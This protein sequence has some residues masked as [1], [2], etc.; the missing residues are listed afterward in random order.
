MARVPLSCRPRVSNQLVRQVVVHKLAGPEHFFRPKGG[1]D[2]RR[3]RGVRRPPARSADDR[4]Q[5]PALQPRNS[6]FGSLKIEGLDRVDIS[7]LKALSMKGAVM[8]I[9]GGWSM[10]KWSEEGCSGWCFE[11]SSDDG[12]VEGEFQDFGVVVGVAVQLQGVVAVHVG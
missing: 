5:A 8:E 2:R 1:I 11:E 12:C 3:Q 6:L 4:E 7:A 9:T 10:G